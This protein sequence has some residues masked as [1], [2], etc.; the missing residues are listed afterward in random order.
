[1]SSTWEW[2]KLNILQAFSAGMPGT[3]QGVSSGVAASIIR[4]TEPDLPPT[5]GEMAVSG[6]ESLGK[7]VG[8]FF[9]ILK[10]TLVAVIVLF[11]I[12]AFVG[13]K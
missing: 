4:E 3:S 9:N 7:F 2:I 10:W 12:W 1:M 6:I 11:I 8:K 13:R 5:I